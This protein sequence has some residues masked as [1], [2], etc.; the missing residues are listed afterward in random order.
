MSTLSGLFWHQGVWLPP[1]S[2]WSDIE[3]P[4]SAQFSHLA[5]PLP[6]AFIMM[7][8]RFFLERSLYR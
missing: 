2:T 7:V 4:G 1:N 6:L 3:R 5:F 8:L